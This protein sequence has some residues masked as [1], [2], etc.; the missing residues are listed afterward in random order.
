MPQ[1][2]ITRPIGPTY[3]LSITT[4]Q[5]VPIGVQRTQSEPMNYAEFMSLPANTSSGVCVTIAPLPNPPANPST[6]TLVFPNAT[7]AAAAPTSF[8]LQP[9]ATRVVPV[10][11]NGFSVSGIASSGTTAVFITPVSVM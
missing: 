1:T 5:S 2:I 6:P 11:R 3:G 10:P 7:S 4:A 8:M 9:N